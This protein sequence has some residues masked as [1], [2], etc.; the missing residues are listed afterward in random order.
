MFCDAQFPGIVSEMFRMRDF[1]TSSSVLCL[2]IYNQMGDL[3]EGLID[4]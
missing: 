3:N 1:C 4:K 2:N